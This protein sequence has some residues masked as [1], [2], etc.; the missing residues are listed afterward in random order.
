MQDSMHAGMRAGV[1]VAG[2][3]MLQDL[4]L[5]TTPSKEQMREMQMGR[6]GRASTSSC[7]SWFSAHLKSVHRKRERWVNNSIPK[8]S[9]PQEIC[10]RRRK[11]WGSERKK[12]C[13]KVEQVKR[14]YK[15][16]KHFFFPMQVKYLLPTWTSKE[17]LGKLFLIF[18]WNSTYKVHAIHVCPFEK[19]KKRK[20]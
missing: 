18:W 19:K 5:C 13:L 10:Y 6:A 3:G 17:K 15:P 2:A 7:S 11:C 16:H 14:H 12:V 9:P 8:H 20:K 1:R 4:S